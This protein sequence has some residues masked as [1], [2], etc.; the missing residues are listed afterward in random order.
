MSTQNSINDCVSRI[1]THLKSLNPNLEL[2]YTEMRFLEILTSM[3]LNNIEVGDGPKSHHHEI[4]RNAIITPGTVLIY[5]ESKNSLQREEEESEKVIS[6]LK[7]D[8]DWN[9]ENYEVIFAD[10]PEESF[11]KM[12]NSVSVAR[13]S[14]YTLHTGEIAYLIKIA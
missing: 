1:E 2:A 5:L 11:R 10:N 6:Y 14:K 3:K 7:K 4:L 9:S 12:K 8:L 13:S